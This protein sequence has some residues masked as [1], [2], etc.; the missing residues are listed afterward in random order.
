MVESPTQRA[1]A[2]LALTQGMLALAEAADWEQLAEQAQQ[3]QQLAQALFAAPVP[4][5][6]AATVAECVE[7]VLKLNQELQRITVAG[8]AGLLAELRD[9]RAN[10]KAADAYLRFSG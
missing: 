8:R 7:E 2:L 10:H 5:A 6:A 1:Q 9:A 4:E 3:R